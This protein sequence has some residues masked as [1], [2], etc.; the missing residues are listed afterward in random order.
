MPSKKTTT[1]V[2]SDSVQEI[3][4]SLAPIYGLKNILS[5][6]LYLFNR[7]PASEQ[8]KIIAKVHDLTAADEMLSDVEADIA[9]QTQKKRRK[10]SKA[11]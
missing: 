9:E 6:G 11:G 4:D 10:S 2:L 1:V 7:L 5:A 8:K 3:K